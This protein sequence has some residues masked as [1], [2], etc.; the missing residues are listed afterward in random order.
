MMDEWGN[1]GIIFPIGLEHK[2]W[3]FFISLIVM[4]LWWFLVSFFTDYFLVL[5]VC[6]SMDAVSN[7][8]SKCILYVLLD[9]EL[10]VLCHPLLLFIVKL[11]V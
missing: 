8:Y 1:V 5:R 6:T 11:G 3:V 9:I 7:S 2:K 10:F 4:K